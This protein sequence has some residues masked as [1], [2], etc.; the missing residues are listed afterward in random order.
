MAPLQGMRAIDLSS[1]G[2]RCAIIAAATAAVDQ[3]SKLLA[4]IQLADADVALTG[5][6]YLTLVYNDT[7]ARGL[8]LGGA[9]LPATLLLASCVL[10]LVAR[11]AA[12]L[13]QVDRAAPWAL[14]LVAGATMG[15]ALDF[16]HTGQGAIDF[17]GLRAEAGSVVFNLADVAAYAGAALLA[18]SAWRVTALLR[19]ERRPRVERPARA[20]GMADT[21]EVV[22]PVPLFTEPGVAPRP[23]AP[24][25]VVGDV[26]EEVVR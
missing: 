22:R 8:T 21:T 13:A 3:V 24:A 20:P 1:P 2:A 9:T 6:A 19:A 5:D 14:G 18:R 10:L 26:V 16:L 25:L 17:L 11:A 15:N 4:T 7:F 23:S 12:P